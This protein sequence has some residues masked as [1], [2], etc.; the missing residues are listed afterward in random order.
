M[1]WMIGVVVVALFFFGIS[2]A[3]ANLVV[4]NLSVGHDLD[5]GYYGVVEYMYIENTDGILLVLV[6][7]WAIEMSPITTGDWEGIR[8]WKTRDRYFALNQTVGIHNITAMALNVENQMSLNYS[9]E[10]PTKD[11]PGP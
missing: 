3:S 1:K 9:A 5:V 8:K 11:I 7:T 10:D 2:G 6:D 4:S